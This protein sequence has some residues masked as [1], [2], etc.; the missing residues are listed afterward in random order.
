MRTDCTPD[1]VL[2]GRL[3]RREIVA[4]FNAGDMS[5][6]GGALLLRRVEQR[7]RVIEGFARCFRDHRDP[8]RISHSLVEL[9]A[10]RV[11]ALVLGYED[12][13][14]HDTLRHDPLLAVAVGK[15]DP[16]GANRRLSEQGK[17]LASSATLNRL[18]LT[19]DDPSEE[20]Y[21]RIDVDSEAV[22]A[23]FVDHFLRAR[24][25][26]GRPPKEIVLDLDNSDVPLH[27]HQEGRFFHG[28]YLS[29]CYLPLYVF[30]GDYLLGVRLQTA[31]GDPARHAVEE[32]QRIV[33]KV[34]TAWPKT[35]I[36]VRG[37]SGFC[38]DTL[39]AWCE[40]NNVDYVLGLA[41]NS[42]LEAK[43]KPELE[44]ARRMHERTGQPARVFKQFQYETLD[45]WTRKRRVVAKAEH[46]VGKANPR[47]VV[48]T[49][50]RKEATPAE[51]YEDHYCPRGEME[52]RIK[53]KQLYLFGTRVS[54]KTLRANQNRL[55]FSAVAYML[56]QTLRDLGLEGTSLAKARAD[57]I[58]VKLLK[59]AARVRISARKVW[60]EL[61]SNCPFGAVFR[62]VAANLSSPTSSAVVM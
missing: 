9:I 30:C 1:R 15:Q 14:D 16:L 41:R 62:E 39:M 44:R 25:P 23:F 56:I 60:V 28:Y 46:L 57:T 18:E 45:S 29:Y 6:D 7:S 36:V 4:D 49:L 21:K 8:S 24:S 33:T 31:D 11:F 61:S 35:R 20:R 52:N 38:R 43:I 10:Q 53:E 51:V 27:G 3:G 12:L 40:E 58:R 26:R 59:I 17:A 42:R 19:P 22:D 37:D 50:S 34:R 13:N 48:T 54:A 55:Y 47:F 2:F 5:S 32:V